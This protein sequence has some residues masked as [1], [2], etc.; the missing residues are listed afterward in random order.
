MPGLVFSSPSV[1]GNQL[2][3]RQTSFSKLLRRKLSQFYMKWIKTKN[4][5]KHGFVTFQCGLE[6]KMNI[7]IILYKINHLLKEFV[8]S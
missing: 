7:I 1:A 8:L 3:S 5:K 6:Q 2:E 4:K